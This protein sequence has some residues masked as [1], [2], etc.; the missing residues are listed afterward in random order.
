MAAT[1][2]SGT[3]NVSWTNNTGGNV[4]V[5]IYYFGTN[6]VASTTNGIGISINAGGAIITASSVKAI[7]KNLA[8]SYGYL[9]NTHPSS[10]FVQNNMASRIVEDHNT[11]P[12]A[13]PTELV[14][15]NTKTLSITLT[16]GTA[17]YN[18]LIIPE[19]G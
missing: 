13:L 18:I 17:S 11:L 14:L 10:S 15:A 2:L 8:F 12:Q 6:N 16:S 5:I 7:G 9:S 4:R 19:D 3:G 1:I